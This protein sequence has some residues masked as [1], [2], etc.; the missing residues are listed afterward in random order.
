[1]K[2]YYIKKIFYMKNSE[3]GEKYSVSFEDTATLYDSKEEAYERIIRE[4]KY[5]LKRYNKGIIDISLEDIFKELD[6]PIFDFSYK[7]KLDISSN[8]DLN[9]LKTISN[10]IFSSIDSKS[11]SMYTEI[12]YYEIEKENIIY[13]L[14]DL[15]TDENK[16]KYFLKSGFYKNLEEISNLK[17]NSKLSDNEYKQIAIFDKDDVND[18]Y[19]LCYQVVL[20]VLDGKIDC[21]NLE[22][23][24]DFLVRECFLDCKEEIINDKRELR[25][26]VKELK[27]EIDKLTKQLKDSQESNIKVNLELQDERKK[28][29]DIINI[30]NSNNKN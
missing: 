26:K 11:L 20:K 29:K 16:S 3:F 25:D 6:K 24:D 15:D 8:I 17:E 5:L 12:C 13:A 22:F 30:I 14:I 28:I 10:G 27:E 19:D 23:F 21:S 9:H 1:M 4:Q 2:K 7:S 18:N